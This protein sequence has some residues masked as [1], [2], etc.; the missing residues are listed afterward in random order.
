MTAD[1]RMF[2]SVPFDNKTAWLDFLGTHLLWHVSLAQQV[3]A[4]TGNT[5]PV[6]PI[7]DGGGTEWLRAVQRTYQGA[8]LALDVPGPPDLESYDL[9]KPEDHASWCFL[10][11]QTA[12]SLRLSAGL[13]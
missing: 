7:G 6:L 9:T 11:S 4:L 13:A 8:A 5:Y 10:V 2:A 3:R 12:A 1:P